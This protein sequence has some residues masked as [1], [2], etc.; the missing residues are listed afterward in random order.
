MLETKPQIY[1]GFL[2]EVVVGRL[3]LAIVVL[4]MG[5]AIGC[6]RNSEDSAAVP[7]N[8]NSAPKSPTDIDKDSVI[9]Y[10]S[11]EE[12]EKEFISGAYISQIGNCQGKIVESQTG[13]NY[14]KYNV[15]FDC[16]R[17]VSSYSSYYDK[18]TLPTASDVEYFIKELKTK[19]IKI[20]KFQKDNKSLTLT[21]SDVLSSIKWSYE[22]K[23]TSAEGYRSYRNAFDSRRKD[24]VDKGVCLSASS[25]DNNN[26]VF[27]CEDSQLSKISENQV[28]I[29]A[30]REQHQKMQSQFTTLFRIVDYNGKE[31]PSYK[32]AVESGSNE[33]GI[34]TSKS[35]LMKQLNTELTA[36][37]KTNIN[38]SLGSYYSSLESNGLD[39]LNNN[40][41]PLF[42]TIKFLEKM[43]GQL[44]LR[45][46]GTINLSLGDN[47]DK[48]VVSLSYEVKPVKN[49]S[50]DDTSIISFVPKTLSII[51]NT[52]SVTVDSLES[53]I[54]PL[55]LSTQ[56]LELE[57]LNIQM[58]L[59]GIRVAEGTLDE[60]INPLSSFRVN[61]IVSELL[62]LS[63]NDYFSD[64]V[65]KNLKNKTL[66]F[67]YEKMKNP[68]RDY[69][70]YLTYDTG[71]NENKYVS[72][73]DK[74][75]R[76][77]LK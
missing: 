3:R 40:F 71:Y 53:K 49:P 63:T 54:N 77:C 32:F 57:K 55:K 29:I 35:D 20:E 10:S 24:L 72:E 27:K 36:K 75:I 9:A 64:K 45:S 76:S 58:D 14:K 34:L 31:A 65:S 1:I 38:I 62:A 48:N 7:V 50:G 37:Y 8:A 61:A 12:I 39:F 41:T 15:N 74:I 69:N 22:G 46:F 42:E 43:N 52:T 13:A 66:V 59:F 21:Q 18:V 5:L 47:S 23:I 44:M 70:I 17:V 25:Y 67:H 73:N 56:L 26:R 30:L 60:K 2:W 33:F 68:C 51:I 28:G 19:K 16:T 6:S 4:A 11:Y